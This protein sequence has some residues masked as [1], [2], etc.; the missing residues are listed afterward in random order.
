MYCL[1]ERRNHCKTSIFKKSGDPEFNEMFSF[2][3]AYNQLPNRMLQ[4]RK[5]PYFISVILVHCLRL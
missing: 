3:V 1:P 4:V 5:R 2:D